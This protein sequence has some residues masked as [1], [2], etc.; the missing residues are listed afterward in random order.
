MTFGNA[1]PLATH[2]SSKHP[3][4]KRKREQHSIENAIS[5][6]KKRQKSERDNEKQNEGNRK[7]NHDGK[8]EER[9]KKRQHVVREE[10]KQEES[11]VNKPKTRVRWTIEKIYMLL[12]DSNDMVRKYPREWFMHFEMKHGSAAAG[13]IR[14]FRKRRQREKIERDGRSPHK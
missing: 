8:S 10:D 4:S 13:A 11:E 7:R 9:A 5:T 1:G 6:S 14:M 12:M 3:K 2:E